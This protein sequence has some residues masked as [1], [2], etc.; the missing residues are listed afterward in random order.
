MKSGYQS[1]AQSSVSGVRCSLEADVTSCPAALVRSHPLWDHLFCWYPKLTQ[2][3]HVLLFGLIYYHFPTSKINNA[4]GSSAPSSGSCACAGVLHSPGSR[5]DDKSPGTGSAFQLS[6]NLF[7]LRGT[8]SWKESLVGSSG[9]NSVTGASPHTP[10][11]INHSS[12]E[13]MQWQLG[14]PSQQQKAIC[15][16]NPSLTPVKTHK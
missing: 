11:Q 3:S 14:Y 15:A 1:P 13:P 8:G 10:L 12:M 5:D 9:L 6:P 7:S 16:S 2:C 4:W